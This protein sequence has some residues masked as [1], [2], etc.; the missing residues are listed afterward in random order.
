MPAYNPCAFERHTAAMRRTDALIYPNQTLKVERLIPYM[1]M[2]VAA[3]QV[4]ITVVS[5]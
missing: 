1:S 2:T 4:G 3:A 5:I